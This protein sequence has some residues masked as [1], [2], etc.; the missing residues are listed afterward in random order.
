[1]LQNNAEPEPEPAAAAVGRIPHFPSNNRRIRYLEILHATP[2][3]TVK[4]FQ[5]EDTHIKPK[6]VKL[7]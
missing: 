1:M 2:Q 6:I 5:R 4:H 7:F 3:C